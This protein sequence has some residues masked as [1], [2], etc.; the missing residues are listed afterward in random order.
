MARKTK[1][2]YRKLQKKQKTKK[3]YNTKSK[4]KR[5]KRGGG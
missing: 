4:Q 2:S 5:I 3:K 1:R